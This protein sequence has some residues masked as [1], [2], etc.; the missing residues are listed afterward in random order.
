M[1]VA[2]VVHCSW[3]TGKP[4]V[5]LPRALVLLDYFRMADITGQSLPVFRVS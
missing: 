3:I 2:V 4:E 5:D 1:I